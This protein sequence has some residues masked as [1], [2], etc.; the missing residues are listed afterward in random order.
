MEKRMPVSDKG[1][2]GIGLLNVKQSIDKYDG[3]LQLK[4]DGNKFVADLFLNS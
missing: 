4:Q 3:N 1:K 2:A